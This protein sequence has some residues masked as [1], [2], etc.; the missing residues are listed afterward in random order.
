MM[1]PPAPSEK[2]SDTPYGSTSREPA[3][4][5][6]P[7]ENELLFGRYRIIRE[8]GR[9]GMGVVMLA[10]DGELDV[11][12]AI[13]LIPDLLVRDNEALDELKHE[14]IR[15]MALTHPNIVR[16]HGFMRDSETAAIIMEFVD[17]GNFIDLKRAH[18]GGCVDAGKL[19]P[20]LEQLCPVLDYAHFEIRLAHRDLKPHNLMYTSSGRLKVAD[21]G[22]S[23]TL[24][25][26]VTRV[27]M[28]A[29]ASGTPA[30]MSPQQIMGGRA[31]HLDDIYALGATIYELMT[32]RPPFYKGQVLAQVLDAAPV[33]MSARREEFGITGKAAIPQSWED[34][35]AACLAKDPQLRPQSAGAVLALLKSS[36]PPT[37]SSPIT[38]PTNGSST[39]PVPAPRR[40]TR[41]LVA[42]GVTAAFSIVCLAA[43][44]NQVLKRD[45]APNVPSHNSND[46]SGSAENIAPA[47]NF[48]RITTPNIL[49]P[50]R[51]GLPYFAFLTNSGGIPPY[52]WSVDHASLPEGLAMDAMGFISGTPMHAGETVIEVT[53]A[54][55]MGQQAAKRLHLAIIGLQD[56]SAQSAPP[57]ILSA[58]ELPAGKVGT[59]YSYS[60]QAEGGNPP[61]IWS[62]D[63]AVLPLGLHLDPQGIISGTPTE[64]AEKMLDITV[65]SA[66]GGSASKPFRLLIEGAPPKPAL[67]TAS[68]EKPHENSLGM[69]FVPC[70]TP[71]LLFSIWLTRV[72]DF[73][74]FV[75]DTDYQAKQNVYSMEIGGKTGFHLLKAHWE[76]P[77][78]AQTDKHPVCGVSWDDAKAFC[79][80]LTEREI[81]SGQLPPG[82]QYR[83]PTDAEWKGLLVTQIP[84][85]PDR[86]SRY[87][88][89]DAWPPPER[90]CNMA[91]AEMR[92]GEAPIDWPIIRGFRD[93]FPRTSKVDQFP[94]N[95]FGIHDSYGNLWQFCE[96]RPDPLSKRRLMRGGSW[97]ASDSEELK[98]KPSSIKDRPSNG[99]VVDAGFRCVIAVAP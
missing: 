2:M 22:I 65:S 34:T 12:V 66:K 73:R 58:D 4:S 64:A 91:G 77:G 25:D 21:F 54:D 59:P 8:L 32:G 50:G 69:R 72:E 80:W 42:I 18:F 95:R 79:K 88:W 33:P 48:L 16:T 40:R 30:Y 94:A 45:R 43:I 15:G 29:S 63:E 37:S 6:A 20:W 14:V 75:T 44:A 10:H 97:G 67:P 90:G 46:T 5:R 49:L 78:F 7:G 93:N 28:R 38:T 39:S 84:G 74:A 51:A 53:I 55:S 47:L 98:L 35:V 56:R 96:D 57:N 83:L 52:E 23:S 19:L 17:G 11:E 86:E 9:G 62:V 68:K 85:K 3:S 71:D 81:K 99:R 24:N 92:D 31:S 89:G 13:K 82:F 87:P 61:Y 41:K 26:T 1:E 70:A 76:E 60:L 36:A 27:S